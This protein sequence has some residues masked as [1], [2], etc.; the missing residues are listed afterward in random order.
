MDGGEARQ[1]TAFELGDSEQ[2]LLGGDFI[3]LMVE[4]L[5][6]GELEDMVEMV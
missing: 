1:T 3:R 4:L 5:F 2:D 6:K